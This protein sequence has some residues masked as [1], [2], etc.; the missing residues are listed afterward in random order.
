MG[1]NDFESF[2]NLGYSSKPILHSSMSDFKGSILGFLG[3]PF[4]SNKSSK[5]VNPFGKKLS[6]RLINSDYSSIA[7]SI[8]ICF[9]FRI[10]NFVNFVG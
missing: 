2:I 5:G 7:S 6:L 9:R 10:S 1:G 4:E 8:S 3:I